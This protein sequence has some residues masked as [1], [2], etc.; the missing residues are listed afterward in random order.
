MTLQAIAVPARAGVC[1]EDIYDIAP[2]GIRRTSIEI[3]DYIRHVRVYDPEPSTTFPF[4]AMNYFGLAERPPESLKVVQSA[5]DQFLG[6]EWKGRVIFKNREEAPICAAC[7]MDVQEH[8]KSVEAKRVAAADPA[9][10][11]PL[12]GHPVHR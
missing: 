10:L 5:L 8:W 3:Y 1:A 2:E 4:L 12:G 9:L 7:D 11:S 6:G